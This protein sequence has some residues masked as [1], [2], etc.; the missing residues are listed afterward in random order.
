MSGLEAGG[1][2]GFEFRVVRFTT[3][4]TKDTKKT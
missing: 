2:C 1:Y 3:R 4:D